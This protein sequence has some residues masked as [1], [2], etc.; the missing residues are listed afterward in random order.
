M[1]PNVKNNQD[2]RSNDHRRLLKVELT[3]RGVGG[4]LQPDVWIA[5]TLRLPAF[6]R[7]TGPV[8]AWP[9]PTP[10]LLASSFVLP[11][12]GPDWQ[13]DI[14]ARN[15]ALREESERVTAGYRRRDEQRRE[16]E[17]TEGKEAIAREVA[18]RN[19]REG[20]PY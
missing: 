3:A 8:L 18:E 1:V 20:W 11:G 12:P 2:C 17:R 10:P 15:V 5:E 19:R 14:A 4:L 16:R 13:A 7:K 6:S 9:P